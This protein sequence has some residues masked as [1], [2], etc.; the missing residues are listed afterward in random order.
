MIL[1]Q[2]LV[3]SGTFKLDLVWGGSPDGSM[4]ALHVRFDPKSCTFFDRT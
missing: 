2:D 1:N 4:F 3:V